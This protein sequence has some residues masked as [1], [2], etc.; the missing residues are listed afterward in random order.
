MILQRYF[1]L[2]KTIIHEKFA[3]EMPKTNPRVFSAHEDKSYNVTQEDEPDIAAKV[4]TSK[5]EESYAL[6]QAKFEVKKKVNMHFMGLYFR[7]KT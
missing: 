2:R 3:H 6:K 1:G 5:Y 7:G 4:P